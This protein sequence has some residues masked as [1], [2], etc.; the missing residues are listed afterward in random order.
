MSK[1]NKLQGEIYNATNWGTIMVFDYKI[2]F[3]LLKQKISRLTDKAHIG[4]K[5]R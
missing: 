3:K 5:L 2:L 1:K 4:G